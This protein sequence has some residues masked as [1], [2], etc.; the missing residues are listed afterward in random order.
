[1]LGIDE[2]KEIVKDK[3]NEVKF[4]IKAYQESSSYEKKLSSFLQA[5]LQKYKSLASIS[6]F[7]KLLPSE[8]PV[9]SELEMMQEKLSIQNFSLDESE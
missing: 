5:L 6:F 8:H 9:I 4:Q 2:S 7:Q 1:L 3:R